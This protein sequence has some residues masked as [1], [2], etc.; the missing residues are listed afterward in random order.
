M[1]EFPAAL[2]N[3]TDLDPNATLASQSHGARHNKVHAEVRAIAERVGTTSSTDPT[4]HSKRLNDLDT[5]VDA[6]PTVSEMNAAIAAAIATAKAALFPVGS[7]YS[8]AGVST[9]PGALLGFGTWVAWGSGRVPVGVDT[10]QTEFDTLEETGGSKTQAITQANLPSGVTGVLIAH[11]GEGGST[12]WQPSGVFS[13]SPILPNTY[14]P[15]G[16]NTSGASSIQALSFDLG[17]SGTAH[18][19]LQPYITVYMWKRTA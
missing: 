2:P 19:N 18:N 4:S 16:G 14:R 1:A 11:G 3:F 17:G 5:A 7:I 13:G 15:P 8:N 12:W 10:G 9:N 6:L